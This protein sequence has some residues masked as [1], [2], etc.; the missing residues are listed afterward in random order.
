MGEG[1]PGGPT[2]L[3]SQIHSPSHFFSS[4]VGNPSSATALRGIIM[5]TEATCVALVQ[6]VGANT[7]AATLGGISFS[8]SRLD[9]NIGGLPSLISSSPN[10]QRRHR[11]TKPEKADE[12]SF[13]LLSEPTCYGSSL[14]SRSRNS[15]R[16]GGPTWT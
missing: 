11:T 15:T 6:I 16:I 7:Q 10:P 13:S 4:L 5:R 12:K 2:P 8:R 3:D 14:I 9:R 1:P